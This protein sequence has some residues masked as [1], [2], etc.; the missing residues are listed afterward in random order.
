MSFKKAMGKSK[1]K[2]SSAAFAV[3]DVVWANP[4]GDE[5]NEAYKEPG[6]VIKIGC[7]YEDD[8]GNDCDDGI[9][10]KFQVSNTKVTVPL[11]AVRPYTQ[12]D[13]SAGGRSTRAS[14]S[15]N[16]DSPNMSVT[17]GGG[18]G[19]VDRSIVTPSPSAGND[20]LVENDNDQDDDGDKNSSKKRAR[21]PKARAIASTKRAAS[22]QTK[23]PKRKSDSEENEFQDEQNQ[24][25]DEEEGEDESNKESNEDDTNVKSSFFD[26]YQ[27]S[28]KATS[29]SEDEPPKKEAA[30]TK[31]PATVH[32]P[33]KQD[34]DKQVAKKNAVKAKA[35]KKKPATKK[36]AKKPN[37][38]AKADAEIVVLMS[39][40]SDEDDPLSVGGDD[41]N[42]DEDD[43]PYVAEYAPTG[44]STCRRCDEV[45]AK[46]TLR[47][48]HIPLFRGKPG[49]RVYRHLECMVLSEDI[50]RVEQIGGWRS[51]KKQSKEDFERLVMRIEESKIELEEEE[52]ALQPDELVQVAFQGETRQPP[53][54]L[55]ANLLPF[56]V[57][58]VSWMYC[59]EVKSDL[60]GGILADGTFWCVRAC[61][62]C[63]CRV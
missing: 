4:H 7:D 13:N 5:W 11:A 43:P 31:K 41:P 21:S 14:R 40:A 28:T 54:G 23:R 60:H 45:I 36:P 8:N 30:V 46:G 18:G 38:K 33:R 56:Q 20:A 19:G 10:V 59:Q 44:R 39:D 61:L 29:D 16:G 63:A 53:Q 32:K 26:K 50:V 58:G 42:D 47:I 34:G 27:D 37:V 15:R 9:L 55:V 2:A 62:P 24:D 22:R 17:N 49:F 3:G 48:S 6:S 12:E 51:I 52:A 1:T 35:T 25:E 57:E